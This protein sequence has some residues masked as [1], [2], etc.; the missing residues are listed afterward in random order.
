MKEVLMICPTC[1]IAGALMRDASGGYEC[2]SCGSKDVH[3]GTADK[4]PIRERASLR[5]QDVA[6]EQ[7]ED[8]MTDEFEGKTLFYV[9]KVRQERYIP[10]LEFNESM[11]LFHRWKH[12]QD[13]QDRGCRYE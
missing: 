12:V 2:L 13:A 8:V 3:V 6:Q 9:C 1:G 10:D 4:H 11:A 7:D 5:R